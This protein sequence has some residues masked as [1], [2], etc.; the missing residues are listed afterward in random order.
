MVIDAILAAVTDELS[1]DSDTVY[2][3]GDQRH[4]TSPSRSRNRWLLPVLITGLLLAGLCCAAV[5]V[6]LLG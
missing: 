4:F 6:A 5:V 2:L 1:P 3:P